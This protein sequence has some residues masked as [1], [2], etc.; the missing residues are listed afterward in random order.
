MLD[1]INDVDDEG[2]V[3]AYLTQDRIEGRFQQRYELM[4]QRREMAGIYHTSD[5]HCNNRQT[6]FNLQ[7]KGIE[8][9]HL[10]RYILAHR[11]DACDAAPGRRYHKVKAKHKTKS[12]SKT[13]A[14]VATDIAQAFDL[15]NPLAEQLDLEFST[16]TDAIEP[17]VTI[18]ESLA[19]LFQHTSKNSSEYPDITQM[20]NMSDTAKHPTHPGIGEGAMTS[21]NTSTPLFSPPGTDF[22]MDWGDACSLGCLPNVNQYLILVMDKGTEYFVSFPTKTRASPLALLKQFVTLI[23]R[24]IRYLRIDGA[25][26]I[27][28]DEIKEYCAENDE[29]LQLV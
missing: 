1:E 22:R 9:N 29:V 26:T 2:Y 4:L 14:P 8:C 28:S 6:V 17:T 27:Q 12:I 24:K 7:A 18:T 11:C 3:P 19:H 25:K 15:Q 23:G 10:K 16:V 5:G 13:A 21:T 20:R